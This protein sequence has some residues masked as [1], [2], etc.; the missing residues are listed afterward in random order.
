MSGGAGP[1]RRPP[2]PMSAGAG[3]DRRPP[4]MRRGPDSDHIRG[5]AD[6]AGEAR[7]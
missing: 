7:C 5:G 2:A 3:P 4:A 1:D 6:P